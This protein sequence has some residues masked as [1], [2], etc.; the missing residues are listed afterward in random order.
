MVEKERERERE[1]ELTGILAGSYWIMC[2]ERPDA[3]RE[4]REYAEGCTQR[5]DGRGVSG[6]LFCL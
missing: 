6:I 5:G 1:K 2:P 4:L 3:E